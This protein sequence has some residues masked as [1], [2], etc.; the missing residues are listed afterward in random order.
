[1]FALR[2]RDNY[3]SETRLITVNSLKSEGPHFPPPCP[4]FPPAFPVPACPDHGSV[5]EEVALAARW[6]A[7]FPSS[8]QRGDGPPLICVGWR[9]GSPSWTATEG[10]MV[11]RS[12]LVQGEETLA[13]VGMAGRGWWCG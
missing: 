6:D 2:L 4:S 3:I 13:L 10:S 12:A 9:C 11:G 7:R 1:V 8:P 5:A